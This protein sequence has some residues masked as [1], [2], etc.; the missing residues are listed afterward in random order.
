MNK[1]AVFLIC[2]LA[3]AA[4]AQ[5]AKQCAAET[6]SPLKC[7][8]S[9]ANAEHYLCSLKM[10]LAIAKGGADIACIIETKTLIEPYYAEAKRVAAKNKST[11]ALLKDYYASWLAGMDGIVPEPSE[12]KLVYQRRIEE[13][14]RALNEKGNRLQL[15]K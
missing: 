12:S 1:V 3:L 13:S 15:E 8:V 4:N 5:D 7:L 11:D 9:K 10:N 14:V 6:K 2:Y